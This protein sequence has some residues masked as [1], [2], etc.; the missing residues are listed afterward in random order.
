MWK[1][2]LGVAL[3]LT[4]G[5]RAGLAFAQ[6]DP[7][8]DLSRRQVQYH[9]KHVIEL[10]G[11]TTSTYRFAAK[12][13]KQQAIEDA[14]QASVSVSRSAQQLQVLEA[15]TQKPGGQRISVPRSSWQVRQDTG[16]PGQSPIFS[17]YNSTTLVFPDVGVGDTLVLA[18]TITT[19]QPMF[20][21]KVS[22]AN[23]FSKAYAFDDVKVVVD[24]PAAMPLKTRAFE[25][26]ESQ[27]TTGG[28]RVI[29]W[30]WRNP[31]PTPELRRDWSVVDVGTSPGYMVS[32]F[33]SWDDVAR[34]YVQRAAPKAVVTAEV[35]QLSDR[36][37]EGKTSVREKAQAIHEWVTTQITYAGNCVGI[38]AVVPRDLDV[39]LKHKMGDCKDHA[40]LLQAL[41]AA[42]G[43]ESHQVLVNAGNLYRLPDVP[44]AQMVNHVLNYIPAL[45]L[46]T[47]STDPS[48]SFGRLP[49]NLYGKPVLA[50][51][52][53]V[54]RSMPVEPGGNAQVMKTGLKL[55]DDGSVEGNV[56]VTLSGLYALNSRSRFRGFDA[57]QRKDFVKEM[58]RRA[59]L[60]AEGS[61]EM[62]D[63]VPLADRFHYSARFKIAKAIAFPGTGGLAIVPWFYNE[64]PTVRWAQQAVGPAEKVDTVC[65]SGSSVEEYEIELP[66]TMQVVAVPD[67]TAFSTAL[68]SYEATYKRDG[69]RLMVRRELDDRTPPQ[70]CSPETSAAFREAVQPVLKDLRQQ[71]LFK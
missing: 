45:E 69:R 14:K 10:D 51:D 46:F 57:Q 24:A 41:L 66:S 47:D 48:T 71:V 20:P 32:S 30:T 70:I 21:G 64:A 7:A 12:I 36:L 11:R 33:D 9:E 58:F 68:L 50:A 43:I 15:Y 22:I 37:A 5:L 28:R 17:D 49:I 31:V 63:P 29:T 56:D 23:S 42:Q 52:A 40:T 59:N 54:P 3:C 65:L 34:S 18:Y 44:V 67:S 25:L 61:I 1:R 2:W 19:R 27:V 13:L 6:V 4:A 16:R 60:D 38:G 53:K 26:A 62:D 8:Q 35:R 55:G 39:V